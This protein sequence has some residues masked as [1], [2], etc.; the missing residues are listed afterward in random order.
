MEQIIDVDVNALLATLPTSVTIPFPTPL[1][2]STLLL[3][4]TD[5]GV[6]SEYIGIDLQGA[7]VNT[8]NPQVR[9]M[10]RGAMHN[11]RTHRSREP[12]GERDGN[13]GDA[14]C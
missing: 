6:T 14:W 1:N 11:S 7:V 2:I 9:G 8:A 13:I 10:G 4:V 12:T 3:G 5:A